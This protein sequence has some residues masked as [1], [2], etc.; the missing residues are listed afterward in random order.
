MKSGPARR[1]RADAPGPTPDTI[2]KFTI[3]PLEIVT[4]FGTIIWFRAPEVP[5]TPKFTKAFSGFLVQAGADV[6]ITAARRTIMANAS[7][8]IFILPAF[9][10]LRN[11]C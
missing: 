4:S 7:R 10:E 5:G 3:P 1:P 6:S 11:L 2:A 8:F 9:V